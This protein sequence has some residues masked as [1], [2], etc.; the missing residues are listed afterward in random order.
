M[1]ESADFKHSGDSVQPCTPVER[2]QKTDN[3]YSEEQLSCGHNNVETFL[4]ELM[5]SGLFGERFV[6]STLTGHATYGHS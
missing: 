2:Q 3:K 5:Y 4:R 1:I 6:S